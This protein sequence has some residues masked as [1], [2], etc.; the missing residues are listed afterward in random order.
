IVLGRG[1]AVCVKRD[2]LPPRQP[3]NADTTARSARYHLAA[4][5][6][7]TPTVR[8]DGAS[9]VHLAYPEHPPET[10]ASFLTIVAAG[11]VVVQWCFVLHTLR[12]V[13]KPTR[14]RR[15]NSIIADHRYWYVPQC[16]MLWL[17]HR[18]HCSGRSF[19]RSVWM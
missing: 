7:C 12:V 5:A 11:S 1:R 2:F 9:E 6:I 18:G 15:G 8:G 16:P 14:L 4:P 10:E 19:H 17:R 3:V 13:R